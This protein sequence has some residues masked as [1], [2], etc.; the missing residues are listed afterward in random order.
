MPQG[1]PLT[2]KK[3][4]EPNTPHLFQRVGLLAGEKRRTGGGERALLLLVVRPE[5]GRSDVEDN[6]SSVPVHIEVA[7]TTGS[8]T[9]EIL[10]SK[11][12]GGVEACK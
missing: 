2:Q 1:P 10:Q 4:R 3:M 5:Q 8:S 7:D 11:K 12:G 6:M 9:R